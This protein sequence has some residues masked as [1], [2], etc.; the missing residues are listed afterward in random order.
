MSL[1]YSSSSARE[2]LVAEHRRHTLAQPV[3]DGRVDDAVVG[4]R[5]QV[6]GRAPGHVARQ[7]LAGGRELEQLPGERGQDHVDDRRLQRAADEPAAQRVGRELA[8]AVGFHARL[9]EQPPV[10]RELPVGRVV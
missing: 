7:R 8:D 5:L 3:Q 4:A 10:D 1:A 2:V 6:D 9:L